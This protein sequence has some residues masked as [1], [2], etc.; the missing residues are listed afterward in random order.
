MKISEPRYSRLHWILP[1]PV[2]GFFCAFT[3]SNLYAIL[4]EWHSLPKRKL[5]NKVVQLLKEYGVYYFFPATYGMGVVG[6]QMWFVVSKVT[7]SAS[8]AK[9]VKTKQHHY[10][11]KSLLLLDE[12]GTTFIINEETWGCSLST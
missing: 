4:S 1:R 7:S 10:N 6:C 12:Q 9:P 5:K 8:N 3:K 2:R 11:S